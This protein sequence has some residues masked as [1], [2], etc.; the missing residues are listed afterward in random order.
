[1]SSNDNDDELFWRHLKIRQV[2]SITLTLNMHMSMIPK[3]II[4]YKSDGQIDILDNDMKLLNSS[5]NISVTGESYKDETCVW[6]FKLQ[7]W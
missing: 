1:M 2:S 3:M 7:A 5:S 6:G 4:K